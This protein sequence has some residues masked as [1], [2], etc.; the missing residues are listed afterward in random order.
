MY[1]LEAVSSAEAIGIGLHE[2]YMK[3]NEHQGDEL[4]SVN[5][6]CEQCSF[7]DFNKYPNDHVVKRN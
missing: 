6:R 3:V 2:S 5:S 4:F 1:V 7:T